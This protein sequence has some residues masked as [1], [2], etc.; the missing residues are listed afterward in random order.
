MTYANHIRR[1]IGKP[2]TITSGFRCWKHNQTLSNSSDGSK[3]PL[4][5]A[6]DISTANLNGIDKYIMIREAIKMRL[7]F[8]IYKHHIHVD[9]SLGEDMVC[10]R[11]EY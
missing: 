11:G 2:L 9:Y 6:L 8:G 7:R 10:W 3:H 5:T 4:G 1:L